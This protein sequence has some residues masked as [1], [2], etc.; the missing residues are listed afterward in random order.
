[1]LHHIFKLNARILNRAAPAAAG[2]YHT[3]FGVCVLYAWF[4]V[5]M[6]SS[7]PALCVSECS[8]HPF[9]LCAHALFRSCALCVCVLYASLGSVCLCP[10]QIP[11]AYRASPSVYTCCV[12]AYAVCKFC[13]VCLCL[14][15]LCSAYRE[16]PSVST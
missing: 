13:S 4:C 11:C 6:P 5:P 12:N 16:S 8:M 15:S 10:L 7:D 1:M 9:V 2:Q 14:Y 3:A